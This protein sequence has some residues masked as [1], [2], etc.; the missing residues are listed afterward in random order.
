MSYKVE[1]WQDELE[2]RYSVQLAVNFKSLKNGKSKYDFGI[3][4]LGT[5]YNNNTNLLCDA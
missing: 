1:K 4:H 3:V 5:P 2:K